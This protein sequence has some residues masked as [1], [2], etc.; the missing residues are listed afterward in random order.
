[1]AQ[2]LPSDP[3]GTLIGDPVA[4]IRPT[5]TL[6]EAA[7]ALAADGVGLLVVVDASGV[8]GV[9]SERDIVQAIAEDLD[10]EVERV[11][12]V[13]STDLLSV[14]ESASVTDAARAMSKAQIRHL[15]I[16]RNG[17]VTGVVSI[18]DV[19]DVLLDTQA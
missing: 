1:M 10:L 6:R 2:T 16:A 8:R 18:R 4:T 12:D 14:E 19:V 5:A 13:A 17:V 11:R 3:V 7:E 15:A 9:I